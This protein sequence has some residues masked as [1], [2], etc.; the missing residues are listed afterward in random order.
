MDVDSS[1]SNGLLQDVEDVCALSKWVVL[2]LP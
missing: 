1:L 2:G